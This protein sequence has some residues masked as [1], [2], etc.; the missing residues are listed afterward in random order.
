MANQAKIAGASDRAR[1]GQRMPL[2][3][4]RLLLRQTTAHMPSKG[5]VT[6]VLEL[7]GGR[8]VAKLV[9]KLSEIDGVSAV[10]LGEPGLI[11]D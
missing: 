9:D 1:G 5:S 6:V 4:S 3:I 8:S 7:P 10:K 11:S 2:T